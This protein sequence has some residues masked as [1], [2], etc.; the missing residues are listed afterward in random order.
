MQ[1]KDTRNRKP[2]S[3]GP[4]GKDEQWPAPGAA[5]CPWHSEIADGLGQRLALSTCSSSTL[6]TRRCNMPSDGVPDRARPS[7]H[8]PEKASSFHAPPRQ[9]GFAKH[10]SEHGN[11][12]LVCDLCRWAKR[13]FNWARATPVHPTLFART[14]IEVKPPAAARWSLGCWV[15]RQATWNP[16]ERY[17]REFCY[18]RGPSAQQIPVDEP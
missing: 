14:W 13:R 4:G 5:D 6:P 8:P 3:S 10:A 2:A 9:H 17:L 16:A 12:T 11:Q 18:I 15:C 1:E 7:I